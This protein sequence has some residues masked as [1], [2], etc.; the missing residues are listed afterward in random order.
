[1]IA[2]GRKITSSGQLKSIF[3][4][5]ELGKNMKPIDHGWTSGRATERFGRMQAG[6]EASRHSVGSERKRYVIRTDDA[7]LSGIRS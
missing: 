6:T 4:Y 1:M 5:T 3:P 7:G 2:F